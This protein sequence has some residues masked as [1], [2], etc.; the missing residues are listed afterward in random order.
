MQQETRTGTIQTV[1]RK[2]AGKDTR[3]VKRHQTFMKRFT[4]DAEKTATSSVDLSFE[5]IKRS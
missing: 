1:D 2:R 5:R 3:A 4:A